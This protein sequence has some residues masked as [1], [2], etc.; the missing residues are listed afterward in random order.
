MIVKELI[1][2]L[3]E[4][5]PNLPVL[6]EG[7]EGGCNDIKDLTEIQIIRDVNLEWYYG[8]HEKVKSLHESVIEE[9]AKDQKFPTSGVLI[10]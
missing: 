1:E 2:K 7:Y 10:G 5:D 9:F 8:A 4:L 6:V 3:Q